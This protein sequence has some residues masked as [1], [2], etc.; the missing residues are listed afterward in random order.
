MK[1]VADQKKTVDVNVLVKVLLSCMH[2]FVYQSVVS[3]ESA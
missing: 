1:F 3:Q 2:A